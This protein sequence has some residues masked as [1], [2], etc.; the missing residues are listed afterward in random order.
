MRFSIDRDRML[1]L[2]SLDARDL[3][4]ALV[5]LEGFAVVGWGGSLRCRPVAPTFG[6][7]PIEGAVEPRQDVP[8][9]WC[10]RVARRRRGLQA[11]EA[12]ALKERAC[13]VAIGFDG[14]S[15]ALVYVNGQAVAGPFALLGEAERCARGK[16]R[17][18]VTWDDAPEAAST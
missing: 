18:V 2:F 9:L 16:D 3:A 1:V 11:Q 15:R 8:G 14:Q 5:E 4:L 13:S 12:R 10:Y 6:G 17:V 7:E